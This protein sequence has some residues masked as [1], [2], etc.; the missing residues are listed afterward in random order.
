M[1]IKMET[2]HNRS[3]YI[4]T[5]ATT[6]VCPRKCVLKRIILGTTAAGA[7]TVYDHAATA[8]GLP[9]ALLKAS[10]VEGV[11]EFDCVMLNGIVVV[12]AGASFLT[13]VYEEVQ[14]N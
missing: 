6:I 8:T 7:I 1:Q 3:V 2:N 10:I 13:V 14:P 11:Y 4:N 12:T 9:T 5:A